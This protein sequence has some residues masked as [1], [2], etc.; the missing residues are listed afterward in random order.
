MSKPED[1]PGTPAPAPSKL[2]KRFFA[3]W[4]GYD[5]PQEAETEGGAAGR[6]GAA[7]SGGESGRSGAGNGGK[8]AAGKSGL[9][10][11]AFDRHGKPLWSATRLQVAEKIWGEGFLSPG[12]AELI[13]QLATPLGLNSAMTVLE[14]GAGLGGASRCIVEA[15]GP[16]VTGLEASPLLVKEGMARSVKAGMGKQAPV[17]SWDPEDFRFPKRVDAILAKESL[18]AV[19]DKQGLLDRIEA[20]LKPKGQLLFTDYIVEASAKDA[21]AVKKW[22]AREPQEP[23]LWCLRDMENGLAQ[24]NFDLRVKEDITDAHRAL[25]LHSIQTLTAYLEKFQLDHE[26]KVNVLDE[27]ELWAN[28]IAALSAGLRCYRFYAIK[29]AQ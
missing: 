27:V 12:G 6:G 24:C 8:A 22:A 1:K 11:A 19:R 21:A 28:R 26:T 7:E 5:L 3:W 17:L 14:L 20:I 25:I 23:F 9:P 10:A 13:T 18:F 16:W 2:K 15:F 29:P 4:E